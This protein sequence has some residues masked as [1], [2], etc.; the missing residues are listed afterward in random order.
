MRWFVGSTAVR[1]GQE[2]YCVRFD[3]GVGRVVLHRERVGVL[4]FCPRADLLQLIYETGSL[5]T[6]G[7]IIN[8]VA[9]KSCDMHTN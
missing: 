1:G 2:T 3:E 9:E 4:F 7:C 5:E 8:Y 6:P